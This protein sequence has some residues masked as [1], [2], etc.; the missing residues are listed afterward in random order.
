MTIRRMVIEEVGTLA[1]IVAIGLDGG[2]STVAGSSAV[3]VR[4]RVIETAGDDHQTLT[5]V[6]SPMVSGTMAGVVGLAAH[7]VGSMAAEPRKSV[8]AVWADAP[9]AQSPRRGVLYRHPWIEATT[10]SMRR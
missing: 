9:V 4:R 8:V 3:T 6:I 10:S 2:K 7:P 1:H 5:W